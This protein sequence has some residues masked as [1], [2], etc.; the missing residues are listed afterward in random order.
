MDFESVAFTNGLRDWTTANEAGRSGNS[1]SLSK[2][3]AL[4]ARELSDGSKEPREARPAAL[5]PVTTVTARPPSAHRRCPY[6]R[7]CCTRSAPVSMN[8]RLVHQQ[9]QGLIC[10]L[11]RQADGRAKGAHDAW[12]RGM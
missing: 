3:L 6:R 7:N 10:W 5:R 8:F 12:R 1:R 9:C 2:A 11:R 4:S